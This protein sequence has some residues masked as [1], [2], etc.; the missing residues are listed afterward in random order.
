MQSASSQV[1]F[2]TSTLNKSQSHLVI[3]GTAVHF[4]YVIPKALR[5]FIGQREIRRSMPP[6]RPK[7][8]RRCA[9]VISSRLHHFFREVRAAL[10]MEE[11]VDRDQVAKLMHAILDEELDMLRREAIRSV[12]GGTDEDVADWK[13]HLGRV[14]M[15]CAYKPFSR[16][17][18]EFGLDPIRDAFD[19]SS[20]SRDHITDGILKLLDGIDRVAVTAPY[21]SCHDPNMTAAQRED[22]GKVLELAQA[23]QV[24]RAVAFAHAA[25]DMMVSEVTRAK[26]HGDLDDHHRRPPV[27]VPVPVANQDSGA[28]FITHPAMT[29]GEAIE[30]HLG[31]TAGK[32]KAKTA[33]ERRARLALF[34][35]AIDTT[36]A[37]DDLSAEM[38]LDFADLL[39][40]LP[41]RRTDKYRDVHVREFRSRA[42]DL[43]VPAAS[44]MANKT[45]INV[46]TM[47][48]AFVNWL[49]KRGH[50]TFDHAK[51][52]SL[53]ISELMKTLRKEYDK[54]GGSSRTSFSDAELRLLFAPERYL[55]ETDKFPE[56]FWLP[57]L[58]LYTGGR[59]QDLLALRRSD[60]K[61][62]P[63]NPDIFRIKGGSLDEDTSRDGIPYIDLTDTEQKEL[64][65]ARAN[66]VIPIHPFVWD[67]LGFGRFIQSFKPDEFLF[68]NQI[69]K[70]RELSNSFGAWF[71]RLRRGAGVG[72]QAGDKNSRD[73]VFHSFRHTVKRVFRLK[74][75]DASIVHEII[76][77]DDESET[78]TSKMYSGDFL[79]EQKLDEVIAKLDF[80]VGLP[81][82]EL[83]MS[84]W[85]KPASQRGAI[86]TRRPR[87]K[88]GKK[89]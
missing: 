24:A 26:A 75:C 40:F 84:P 44:L 29:I 55:A 19:G 83:V 11:Q 20:D 88:A 7:L 54:Q 85:T 10:T 87:K 30:K 28:A 77:H 57:I 82:A 49:P 81:L 3:R 38:V 34:A 5:S 79:I 37:L 56:R 76:G 16:K 66:R 46:L 8:L 63:E 58:A 74:R 61:I 71:T 62:T 78:T 86:P 39:R 52:L 53:T 47:L 64:K 35:E 60:I 32:G 41:A 18:V 80:H 27:D 65:T 73:V 13:G 33:S 48:R 36:V 17:S 70:D 50:I 9:I 2:D 6:A 59:T 15:S 22:Q 89:G 25:S 42:S 43:A 68:G 4:R 1:P 69:N 14:A 31:E 51:C 21:I 72:R 23:I 12:S 45:K 67:G